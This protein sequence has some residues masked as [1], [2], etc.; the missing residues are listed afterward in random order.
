MKWKALP[1]RKLISYKL[2]KFRLGVLLSITKLFRLLRI[3]KF[4]H[5]IF[6]FQCNKYHNLS[7][8]IYFEWSYWKLFQQ[9]LTDGCNRWRTVKIKE[10]ESRK[11]K[12]FLRC[13]TNANNKDAKSMSNSYLPI[14][15]GL[16]IW[17][18][19]I[20]FPFRSVDSFLCSFFSYRNVFPGNLCWQYN[21]TFCPLKLTN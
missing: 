3:T 14:D 7:F 21:K 2:F 10:E 1:L 8:A 9:L 13:W 12:R 11:K 5:Q 6:H 18:V 19:C 16:P 17:L 15:L 4:V 20:S